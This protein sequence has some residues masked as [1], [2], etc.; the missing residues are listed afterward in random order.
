[1]LPSDNDPAK[2]AEARE[3][4]EAIR[5]FTDQLTEIERHV[6]LGRYYYGMPV[7]TVSER[8][9]YSESRT[10][11]LLHRLRGRLRKHLE[12]EGLL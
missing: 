5:H 3:L 4:G 8:L 2:E 12:K 6:F 9:G 11:S 10:K 7:K 1:M